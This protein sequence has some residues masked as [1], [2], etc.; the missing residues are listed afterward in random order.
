MQAKRSGGA[1]VLAEQGSKSMH[2]IKP[3][4]CEHLSVFSCIN[5]ANGY[6]PNLYILKGTYFLQD[7]ISRSEKGVAMG[8]QSNAWMTK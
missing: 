2:S 4:Q 3:D 8:M 1:T 5:A 6:I 7:Y